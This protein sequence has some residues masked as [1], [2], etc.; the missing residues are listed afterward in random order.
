MLTLE[1][2]KEI[3]DQNFGEPFLKEGMV[4]AD[5]TYGEGKTLAITI[6]RRDVEINEDGEV[7]GSGTMLG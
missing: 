6:G 4:T 5:F 2:L 7:V 1:R 3:I